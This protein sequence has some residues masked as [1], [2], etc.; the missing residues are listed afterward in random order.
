[1]PRLIRIFQSSLLLLLLFT[2]PLRAEEVV[3]EPISR[4]TLL[5]YLAGKEDFTLIDARSA[6]EY[7]AGHVWGASNV[8]HDA[9]LARAEGLPEERDAPLVVYCKSG[10]RAL[11]LKRRL[12]EEGYSNVRVLAPAQMTWAEELPVFNCGGEEPGPQVLT[13]A[14]D[15]ALPVVEAG[16]ETRGTR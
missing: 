12:E 7:A 1:M 5:R 3:I 15:P 13:T 10:I 8:P 2:L 11:T 16:S 4:D 9:D 14:P 6:E